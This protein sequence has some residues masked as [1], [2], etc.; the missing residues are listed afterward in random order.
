MSEFVL[1]SNDDNQNDE[2][3]EE[4]SKDDANTTDDFQFD[5]AIKERFKELEADAT[6]LHDLR[7]TVDQS[8]NSTLSEDEKAE[9]DLRSIYVGNVSFNYLLVSR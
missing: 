5:P 9:V 6:K 1:E 3:S 8:A 7:A 2:F 4:V